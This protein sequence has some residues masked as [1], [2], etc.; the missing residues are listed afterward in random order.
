MEDEEREALFEVLLNVVNSYIG[1]MV[2]IN[3]NGEF[4]IVRAVQ[5]LLEE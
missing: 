5:E 2:G 1:R 3:E 4:H